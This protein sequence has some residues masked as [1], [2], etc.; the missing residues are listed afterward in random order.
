MSARCRSLKV[1][2]STTRRNDVALIG[3]VFMACGIAALA[4]GASL[5]ERLLIAGGLWSA[6]A[7]TFATARR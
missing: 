6:A 1:T 7:A 3:I 4:I 5:V 2:M